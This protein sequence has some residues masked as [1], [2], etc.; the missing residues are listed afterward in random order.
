MGHALQR[1][2][3]QRRFQAP[4]PQSQRQLHDDEHSLGWDVADSKILDI[5]FEGGWGFHLKGLKEGETKLV[6]KV[7]HHDHAD[8]KTPEIKVVVDKALDADKCPFQEDE[9]ED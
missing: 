9:D 3:R 2:P 1:L 5:H 4:G 7:K 8:A 6:L